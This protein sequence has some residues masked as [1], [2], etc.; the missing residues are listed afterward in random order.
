MTATIVF[1]LSGPSC[2]GKT[3]VALNLLKLFPQTIVI[4]QDDFYKPDNQ[5]PVNEALRIQ[6]WDCP[7]SFDMQAMVKSIR[8][9]RKQFQSTIAMNNATDIKDI[10]SHFASQWANPPE[11]V[12][13]VVDTVVLESLRKMILQF[14]Q[15]D[16]LELVPFYIILVDGILLFHD[17]EQNAIH[18]CAEFDAGIFIYAQYGTLKERREARAGYATKEAEFELPDV[19]N[20][21]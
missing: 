6:D 15:I 8:S 20:A 4:H 13:K 2:S 9:L 1:G 12:E 17:S 16:S 5:I 19:S 11:D 21:R 10:Q 7:T 3:T 18:P 14:L